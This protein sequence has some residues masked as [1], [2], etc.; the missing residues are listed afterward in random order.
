MQ[1]HAVEPAR[2]LRRR[3]GAVGCF[4]A[5]VPRPFAA[6]W[7]VGDDRQLDRLRYGKGPF[8]KLDHRGHAFAALGAD[9]RDGRTHFFG[10]HFRFETAPA[11]L[12]VVG[13]VEHDERRNTEAEN[14]RGERQVTPEVRGV[15][16]E[17]DRVGRGKIAPLA[18]KHVVRDLLV[19]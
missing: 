16:N 8:E 15:E 4:V 2:P 5:N 14:R 11:A 17:D 6:L 3:G 10:Q 7:N 13:H 1:E 9:E 19:L 18:T 12:E